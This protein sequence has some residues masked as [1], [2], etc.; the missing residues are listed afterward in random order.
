MVPVPTT[1]YFKYWPTKSHI[2]QGVQKSWHFDLWRSH[3][4]VDPDPV[5][6]GTFCLSGFGSEKGEMTNT[7]TD[8]V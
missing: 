4:V 2:A 6:S 3:N 1:E 8:T 7:R 5:G